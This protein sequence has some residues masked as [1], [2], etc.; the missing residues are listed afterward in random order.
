MR[1]THADVPAR[2]AVND[3]NV[4]RFVA[5]E[6][7]L[8]VMQERLTS[9]Q[10]RARQGRNRES[11]QSHAWKK[12]KPKDGEPQTKVFSGR[13]YH[14]CR[15]HEAW[16]MHAPAECTLGNAQPP[17]AAAAAPAAER[18][19][20]ASAATRAMQALMYEEDSA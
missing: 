8:R 9:N 15:F 20:Y 19:S 6:A 2:D 4:A 12:V 1:G 16:T 10:G 18:G 11:D 3:A 5:M 13:T 7:T 14:W 17:A